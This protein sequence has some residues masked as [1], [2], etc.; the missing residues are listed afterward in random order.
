MLPWIASLTDNLS[1]LA[2]HV[3]SSSPSPRLDV[4]LIPSTFNMMDH[5]PE[6]CGTF[7]GEAYAVTIPPS[8]DLPM[9][10]F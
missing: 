9:L 10:S 4:V 5:M 8:F 2:S 7:C 6:Q 1:E 3:G